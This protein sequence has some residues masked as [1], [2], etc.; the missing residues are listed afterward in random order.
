MPVGMWSCIVCSR[1]L[2]VA[3]ARAKP[4]AVKRAEIAQACTYAHGVLKRLE[5]DLNAAN[6][7]ALAAPTPCGRGVRAHSTAARWRPERK[8]FA[9]RAANSLATALP[10]EQRPRR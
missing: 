6:P 10:T 8:S 5:R 7:S 4:A 1:L 9:P 3:A 2:S